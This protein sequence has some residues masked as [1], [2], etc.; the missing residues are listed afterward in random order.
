MYKH[1]DK[2]KKAMPKKEGKKKE[3]MKYT[4]SKD[5]MHD[6]GRGSKKKKADC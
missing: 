6:T 3:S 4:D 2:G 5:H 1:G